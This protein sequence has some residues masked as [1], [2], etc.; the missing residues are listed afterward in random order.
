MAHWR[1]E[2]AGGSGLKDR[3]EVAQAQDLGLDWNL[4]GNW[5]VGRD[6]GRGAPGDAQ[7]CSGSANRETDF[8]TTDFLNSNSKSNAQSQ[9]NANRNPQSNASSPSNAN[10]NPNVTSAAD[11]NS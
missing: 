2:I 11:L 9:R 1:R 4:K 7:G 5:E 6:E 3:L 10:P 8:T